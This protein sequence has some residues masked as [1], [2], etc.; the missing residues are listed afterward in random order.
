MKNFRIILLLC[1]LCIGQNASCTEVEAEREAQFYYNFYAARKALDES[2]YS[3][4]YPLL[5]LCQAIHPTDGKTQDYLGLIYDAIGQHDKAKECFARAYKYAPND[6]YMHHVSKLMDDHQVEE[7]LHIMQG[8]VQVHPEDPDAWN[9]LMQIAQEASDYK[10]ATKAIE[11]IDRILGYSRYTAWARYTVAIQQ[12]NY[13]Q[14]IQAI[15]RYL[16]EDPYDEPFLV[17]KALVLEATHAAAKKLIPVYKAILKL[18]A[19]NA[20]ILNN[21]AYYLATHKGDL[22]L[23]EQMSFKAIQLQPKTASYLDT[24]GWILHLLGKDSLAKFYLENALDLSNNDSE[25]KEIRQHLEKIK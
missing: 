16:E 9:T 21:Y 15:D 18:D 7:A 14:A 2:R 11:Q 3:D 12:L 10:S 20:L 17:Q 24:Y 4:A 13:R 19:D 22:T 6:L 25:Q 5:M 8:A 1:A 23:A